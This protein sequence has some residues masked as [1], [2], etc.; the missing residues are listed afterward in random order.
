MLTRRKE[1]LRSTDLASDAHA[2]L[3][4]FALIAE[5]DRELQ[6]SHSPTRP[7]CDGDDNALV[8]VVGARVM[9]QGYLCPGTVRFVGFHAVKGGPRCGVELD[10]PIGNNDGV[11]GGEAYFTCP[12]RHGV[13]VVPEKITQHVNVKDVGQD[14]VEQELEQGT[15]QELEHSC[16]LDGPTDSGLGQPA[17]PPTSLVK[18]QS[19]H[20][21]DEDAT[22]EDETDYDEDARAVVVNPAIGLEPDLLGAVNMKDS[23]GA[24]SDCAASVLPPRISPVQE[25]AQGSM[26]V[27][28]QSMSNGVTPEGEKHT[29]PGH[30]A[31]TADGEL[32]AEDAL[33]IKQQRPASAAQDQDEPA[34]ET[35]LSPTGADADD[36][37]TPPLSPNWSKQVDPV[38]NMDETPI[39]KTMS[40]VQR[41]G[42]GLDLGGALADVAS[43]NVEV[44]DEKMS[45]AGPAE[46][47]HAMQWSDTEVLSWLE[48]HG[49][50]RFEEATEDWTGTMLL[51]LVNDAEENAQAIDRAF[52]EMFDL[53]SQRGRR[54][55]REEWLEALETLQVVAPA[56]VQAV[57]VVAV[58]PSPV[59]GPAVAPPKAAAESVAPASSTAEE[60]TPT[61]AAPTTAAEPAAPISLT[62]EEPVAEGSRRDPV[63]ATALSPAPKPEAD[64]GQALLEKY[65]TARPA[66]A[67]ATTSTLALELSAQSPRR[68]PTPTS[69]SSGQELLARY[70]SQRGAAAPSGE[71]LLA[72]YKSGRTG[73]DTTP[74]VPRAV[75][76]APDDLM[77]RYQKQPDEQSAVVVEV[78]PTSS[79]MLA[80]KAAEAHA[81]AAPKGNFSQDVQLT[82]EVDEDTNVTI[83]NRLFWDAVRAVSVAIP[84]WLGEQYGNKAVGVHFGEGGLR[85]LA[86]LEPFT[87]MKTLQ[88]NGNEL[89]SLDSLPILPCVENLSVRQNFLGKLEDNLGALGEKLPSLKSLN[90]E[91]QRRPGME[92]KSVLSSSDPYPCPSAAALTVM[93]TA[94]AL[95]NLVK[96]NDNVVADA[97]T[98]VWRLPKRAWELVAPHLSGPDIVAFGSASK[99]SRAVA[100]LMRCRTPIMLSQK[101]ATSAIAAAIQAW[102]GLK[103]SYKHH[104]PADFDTLATLSHLHELQLIGCPNITSAA[105]LEFQMSS[106]AKHIRFERCDQ[107]VDGTGLE[108]MDTV[109]FTECSQLNRVGMLNKTKKLSIVN[110]LNVSTND[111]LYQLDLVPNLEL[112]GCPKLNAVGQLGGTVVSKSEDANGVF[113]EWKRDF[114]TLEACPKLRELR[115]IATVHT[116][117]LVDCRLIV[118]VSPLRTVHTLELTDCE[119]IKDL[120]PL[121]G[122]RRVVLRNLTRVED[123]RSLARCEYVRIEGCENVTNVGP[124]RNVPKLELVNCS[125]IT[126]VHCSSGMEELL[127]QSCPALGKIDDAAEVLKVCI[128]DCVALSDFAALDG[129]PYLELAD[130]VEPVDLMLLQNCRNVKVD[131]CHAVTNQGLLADAIPSL[132][133]DGAVVAPSRDRKSPTA[134]SPKSPELKSAIE[135][136][137]CKSTTDTPE[138]KSAI[139]TAQAWMSSKLT[140]TAS[141]LTETVGKVEEILKKS[142][143]DFQA[144]HPD[145][146]KK[147]VSPKK[148]DSIA[149]T[150]QP[151]AEAEQESNDST[152]SEPNNPPRENNPLEPAPSPKCTGCERAFTWLCRP[153]PDDVTICRNCSA[154]H[155]AEVA[156]EEAAAAA[157]K[158]ETV[159]AAAKEEEVAAA[160]KED[161]AAAA[162]TEESCS[163][164][165][166]DA[167][168]VEFGEEEAP[169]DFE[170]LPANR[171]IKFMDPY[172]GLP[173]HE[174]EELEHARELARQELED[175]SAFQTFVTLGHAARNDKEFTA[176]VAFF[177]KALA[178][179]RRL[180]GEMSQEVGNVYVN[181]GILYGQQKDHV[182]EM[183]YF[184]NALPIFQSALGPKHV[185][186]AMTLNNLGIANRNAGDFNR[187]MMYFNKALTLYVEVLGAD[188]SESIRTQRNIDRLVKLAHSK[189]QKKGATILN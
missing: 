102:P 171:P 163:I 134:T 166:D 92:V 28:S 30:A 69:R 90:F 160:A 14:L 144:R 64:S 78:H 109:A 132:A 128:S 113:R 115:G 22:S 89:T 137:E 189:N 35:D 18:M 11:V 7:Q 12:A 5:M 74:A 82:V 118:D 10:E 63:T 155:K 37:T 2:R 103:F 53:M 165:E 48:E 105:K 9:V 51:K 55:A 13:L 162:A 3:E 157:A 139:D 70:K 19:F 136:P 93:T 129:V 25:K 167:A 76:P 153:D 147:A 135:T 130:M 96:L 185:H 101:H 149:P 94:W 100:K 17:N 62:S 41:T 119:R 71:D 39:T 175:S 168:P 26:S 106:I 20:M 117:K 164:T 114:L 110:C 133:V 161:V 146:L 183:E 54:K 16:S 24:A 187:S 172:E 52:E 169:A 142:V 33:D 116:L 181:L 60:T 141:K 154:K 73:L 159:A 140:E 85:N 127:V 104:G 32:L 108:D 81:D 91:S 176:A 120:L 1:E 4:W 88:L 123:V 84:P 95:P 173:E 79:E 8:F 170:P 125:T 138:R 99:M 186:V 38:R 67:A 56:V 151:A 72:K 59:T 179:A 57:A 148:T 23:L 42:V 158:E 121:A 180:K 36:R 44:L 29:M 43:L 188:H 112:V 61:V 34:T 65:K 184:R 49:L 97:I 152:P 80:A 50:G 156:K 46:E 58:P 86:G 143:E 174:R 15:L 178:C 6:M 45:D 122:C 77:A 107:L 124:L 145:L 87:K 40:A 27:W 111:L 21:D 31:V 47:H 131:R 177:F 83:P 75:A 150:P 66:K 98:G 126:A 68:L 182:K